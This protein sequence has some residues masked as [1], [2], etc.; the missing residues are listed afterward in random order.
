MQSPMPASK[1][2]PLKCVSCPK[3]GKCV[4]CGRQVKAVRKARPAQPKGR[5]T[6]AA[7]AKAEGDRAQPTVKR[8]RPISDARVRASDGRY[9]GSKVLKPTSQPSPA[10]PRR[11]PARRPVPGVPAARVL[12]EHVGVRIAA[13]RIVSIRERV[14]T[15]LMVADLRDEAAHL[16][17]IEERLSVGST[18]ALHHA[19]LSTRLLLQG[20]ADYCFP[21]RNEGPQDTGNRLIAFVE[22]SLGAEHTSEEHRLFI[23]LLDT[24]KRFSG[25]GPHRIYNPEEVNLYFLRV[26][27]VMDHIARG[28]L[29]QPFRPGT[30]RPAQT[31]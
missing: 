4:R 6:R 19:A 1:A 24:V 9:S 8:G 27:E 26:L 16:S 20:V 13:T 17:A 21:A 30:R 7:R 29:A 31:Q 18:P 2:K 14:V 28:Y 5:T 15:F 3:C 11:P 12:P 23:A 25:R 22:S 10:L